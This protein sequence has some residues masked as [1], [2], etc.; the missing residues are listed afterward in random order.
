MI[1]EID[2]H[3]P[4]PSRGL[5]RTLPDLAPYQI[6]Q[7]TEQAHRHGLVRQESGLHLTG[8]GEDL[9]ELYDTAARWARQHQYPALVA[10]FATR[11]RHTLALLAE[12]AVFDAL[13]FGPDG[14]LPIAE[15]AASPTGPWNLLTQWL[16]ANPLAVRPAE[17]E[18]AA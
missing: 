11:I 14:A 18:P 16:R 2:E 12:P 6:R 5:A 3:G 4:I 8:S 13:S 10:D 17:G 15:A 1:T 7:A 9:A